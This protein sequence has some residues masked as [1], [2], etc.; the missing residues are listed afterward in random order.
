M[1]VVTVTPGSLVDDTVD[2]YVIDAILLAGD[3][4]N[5]QPLFTVLAGGTEMPSN[6]SYQTPYANM[7]CTPQPSF[8]DITPYNCTGST[9]YTDFYV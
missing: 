8:L 2:G 5:Y 1:N 3:S 7:D 9:V 6:V 4:Q